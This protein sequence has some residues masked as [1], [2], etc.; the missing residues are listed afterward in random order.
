MQTGMLWFDND[1]KT[2][3]PTKV[4]RAAGYY[5]HKYGKA[6]TICFAAPN[7]TN[8]PDNVDGITVKTNRAIMASHLWIG[9][10]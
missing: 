10:E 6:P 1:P 3:I 2:D 7:F 8:P 9:V 5:E 4:R